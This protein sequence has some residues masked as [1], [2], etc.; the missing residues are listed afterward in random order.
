MFS[1]AVASR[2]TPFALMQSEVVPEGV[3]GS[4][5]LHRL[6][7]ESFGEHRA[8]RT[9]TGIIGGVFDWLEALYW[10]LMVVP[11]E[12]KPAAGGGVPLPSMPEGI[13]KKAWFKAAWSG[14]WAW[15]LWT[16]FDQDMSGYITK[17]ELTGHW[18]SVAMRAEFG[19]PISSPH[20]AD[21]NG[22]L[23]CMAYTVLVY[24]KWDANR[25]GHLDLS[26]L[27]NS[28]LRKKPLVTDKEFKKWAIKREHLYPDG[29]MALLWNHFAVDPLS[30]R[31]PEEEEASEGSPATDPNATSGDETT[32]ASPTEAPPD[33]REEITNQD[34]V[35][36]LN[37]WLAA[38]HATV[39]ED[40]RGKV[41]A[42]EWFDATMNGKWAD[43]LFHRLDTDKSGDISQHEFEVEMHGALLNEFGGAPPNFGNHINSYFSYVGLSILI[44]RRLDAD[45]DGHLT[46]EEIRV[47]PLAI[48]SE[49]EG[50]AACGTFHTKVEGVM[51]QKG[52]NYVAG[53]NDASETIELEEL[54]SAMAEFLSMNKRRKS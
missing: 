13:P 25:D 10:D 43:T 49:E 27:D 50:N 19:S 28:T 26:E 36:D 44:F 35:N 17:A 14:M 22:Y 4:H 5:A 6:P 32:A 20:I 15:E 24:N 53:G 33:S 3:H 30:P 45:K 46:W 47:S 48:V 12:V 1:G 34:I 8:S 39:D 40:R 9:R 16:H 29:F 7:P 51:N 2:D 18:S 11:D 42:S 23:E 38:I 37:L 31:E 52:F 41:E 54:V 21:Y